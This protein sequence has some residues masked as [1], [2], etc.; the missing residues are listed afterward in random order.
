MDSRR[1]QSYAGSRLPVAYAEQQAL[2]P[3]MKHDSAEPDDDSIDLRQYWEII[4][5]HKITIA[6]FTLVVLLA[7]TINTALQP[8]VY[9]S[10]LTLQ[11]ERSSNMNLQSEMGMYMSMYS[12]DFYET[13]YELLKS[14]SLAERVARDMNITSY[15]QL[16]GPR[17]TGTFIDSIRT[18]IKGRPSSDEHKDAESEARRP[19]SF[20]GVLMAGLSVNP[21]KNSQLTYI[22]FDSQSPTFAAR[23]VNSYAKN[24]MD[25]NL[26][27]RIADASYAQTFLAEQIKQVRADL[28]DSEHRLIEYAREKKIADLDDKLSGYI[29]QLKT[30][31]QKLLVVESQR[32]EAQATYEEVKSGKGVAGIAEVTDNIVIQE[33]KQTLS[34]LESEY[35][36]KLNTFKPAYPGMQKLANRISSLKAKIREETG[37]ISHTLESTYKA[38]QRQEALIKARIKQINQEV[39]DLRKR[40]TDYQTLK[41]D[42]DTNVLL[43]DNLLQQTKEVGVAAGVKANNISVVDAGRIPASPYKPNLQKN[44]SVALLIGLFGGVGLAFLFDKL[45]DTVKSGP[46]LEQLTGLPVLGIVPAVDKKAMQIGSVGMLARDDPKS[47]IAEAYRSFRTSLSLSTVE[48]HPNILH[49]T[50]SGVGEGKT[51]SALSVAFTFI[52][53]GAKVL[54]VD[55]DLRS[56]SVHREFALPNTIGLTSFL[57]GEYKLGKVAHKVKG[58]QHLWIVP[59]GPIP[60]N[61]AELLASKKMQ[62]FLGNAEDQFDIVIIDSPPVLGLADALVL[63]NMATA[64][65]LVVD[66]G[67]TKKGVLNDTMKRLQGVQANLIGTML[68]K[69]NQ[70][71]S[72]YRYL[73]SYYGLENEEPREKLAS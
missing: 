36:D 16:R 48:G 40:T 32:I 19:E 70:G 52:Q 3:Y 14:Y 46:H 38:A 43:Y 58:M 31:N 72:S 8:P 60:P 71:H 9:R 33:Y 35:A 13:Q 51:T 61:P 64:T 59:A 20:A 6:V 26:E 73:Y 37:N 45:D 50:S 62:D 56:P 15:D 7:A 5:K 41:R 2:M 69:F 68:T 30:L 57:A 34:K 53:A 11:I 1:Y 12:A 22:S 42:V 4:W 18:L 47:P 66:S 54:L 29:D 39:L 21:I 28:E 25:M 55:A 44:L 24:F 23:A 67:T 49:I 17:D 10:T 63:S 27:K 65:V